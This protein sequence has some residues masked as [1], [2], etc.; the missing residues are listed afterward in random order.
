[1]PIDP[2]PSKPAKRPPPPPQPLP[3][4]EPMEIQ[5]PNLDGTHNL[6]PDPAL[7]TPY[8]ICSLLFTEDLLEKHAI[9]TNK[10]R[11]TNPPDPTCL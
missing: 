8:A 3:D 4:Y 9:Y 5:K 7:Y 11:T 10:Y 1:M 6:G 2:K